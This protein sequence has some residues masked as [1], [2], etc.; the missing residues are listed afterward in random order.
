MWHWDEKRFV[1]A[2]QHHYEHLMPAMCSPDYMMFKDLGVT[3]IRPTVVAQGYGYCDW[4]YVGDRKEP[5]EQ[6]RDHD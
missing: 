1:L 4:W 3:F 6:F 2:R 5:Y